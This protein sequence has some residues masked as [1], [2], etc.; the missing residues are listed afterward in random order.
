VARALIGRLR[1]THLSASERRVKAARE[2]DREAGQEETPSQRWD[3][4]LGVSL[5]SGAT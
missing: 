3:G 2:D 4:L 5:E 1:R